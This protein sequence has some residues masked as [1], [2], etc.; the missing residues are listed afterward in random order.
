MRSAWSEGEAEAWMVARV[1]EVSSASRDLGEE[2]EDGQDEHVDM[3][4]EG[5]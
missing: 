5:V 4:F 2:E 1:I 3:N